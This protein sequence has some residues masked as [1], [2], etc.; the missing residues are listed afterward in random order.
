MIHAV[1]R[2]W[3]AKSGFFYSDEMK[4]FVQTYVKDNKDY[5]KHFE[6]F[7]TMKWLNFNT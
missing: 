1:I 3:F 2:I 6:K 5:M 7:G 4:Q